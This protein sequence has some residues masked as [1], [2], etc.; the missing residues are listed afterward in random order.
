MLRYL[1]ST[2]SERR[3]ECRRIASARRYASSCSAGAERVSAIPGV[4]R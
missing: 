3:A 4:A 1:R 2:P